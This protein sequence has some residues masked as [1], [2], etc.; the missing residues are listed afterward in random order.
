MIKIDYFFIVEVDKPRVG[1]T[2]DKVQAKPALEVVD[3]DVSSLHDNNTLS[4]EASIEG[5]H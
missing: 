2:G 4:V 1:E 5:Y 3:D